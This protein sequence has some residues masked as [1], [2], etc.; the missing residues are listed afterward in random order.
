MAIEI[1]VGLPSLS[2]G[3]LLD[4]AR[5]MQ[6]PVLVSANAFSRWQCRQGWRE[7]CGW[8][9]GTLANAH[10]LLSVDLDSAGF[11]LAVKERGI[12]W[13][14]DDYITLAG[15]FPFRRFASL[16][17]CCEAEIAQD[18]DEVLDRI[19]RTIQ[20][21]RACH[22]RAIDAGIAH[23]FM[24]VL[25]GR[26]PEDYLRS[27]DGIAHLVRPGQVVGVGSLCRR[28]VGGPDGLVAVIDRLDR[29]LPPEVRLHGFGVKGTALSLPAGFGDRIASIDSQAYGIAA[30][31]EAHAAG[32]SKTGQMVAAH[33]ARWTAR[34]YERADRAVPAQGIL[35]LDVPDPSPSDR[36]ER[37]LAD[38]RREIRDLIADGE[39]GHDQI[40]AGWIAEWAADML[41]P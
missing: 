15:S 25:Q 6:V 4:R 23:A 30:R 21:N 3:P 33:M 13:T 9:T 11:V 26:R 41:D 10:G 31:R 7:W 18:R 38:A 14:I 20:L 2:R 27:W 22:A 17:L 12:P 35:E 32:R 34:Q 39:I 40:T 5:A 19:A 29:T 37:A 16:D 24:P 28:H 8:R 36:W 1:V